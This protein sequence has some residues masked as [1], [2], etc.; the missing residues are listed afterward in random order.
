[1]ELEEGLPIQLVKILKDEIIRPDFEDKTNV[2]ESGDLRSS[3]SHSL[4]NDLEK[5]F[6][7]HL[8]S[9]LNE[10]VDQV[11]FC[12][13][14]EPAPCVENIKMDLTFVVDSSSSIG[15]ENFETVKNFV[16][17][18]VSNFDIGPDLTRVRNHQ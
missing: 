3:T 18:I 8:E 9:V 11:K 14:L 10:A 7:G 16:T 5:A 13:I 4:L 2:F 12:N 1:M 17:G 6:N 15:K